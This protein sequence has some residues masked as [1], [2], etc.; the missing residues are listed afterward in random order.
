MMRGMVYLAKAND[1]LICHCRCAT[2]LVSW[3]P[4]MDCPWCGCGWLFVCI[5][6]RKPFTFAVGIEVDEPLAEI[7]RR[8][9]LRSWGEEPAA[10]DVRKWVEAMRALLKGVE[11]GKEYAY[12]DGWFL[13]TDAEAV[14]CEGW[15]ARHTLAHPPQLDARN[16]PELLNSTLGNRDYW[17]DRA[18]PR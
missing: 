11:V 2:A 18:I 9:L 17:R 8:D 5:E 16:D 1:D 4:Q 3:P 7:A 15:A 6:C 10:E 14:S 12:L 13:P